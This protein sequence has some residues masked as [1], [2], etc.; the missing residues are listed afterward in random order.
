MLKKIISIFLVVC[1][2]LTFLVSCGNT[3]NTKTSGETETLKKFTA[4]YLDYFDTVSVIV[5]YDTDE[6][7]FNEKCEFI[8]EQLSEYNNLYDIYKSYEGINNIRTINQNAGL[9]PVKVDARIIG[10]LD[11]CKSVFDLTNG[12]VNVAFGSV[13]SIWHDYRTEGINNP[14]NAKLPTSDELTEA[15]KHTD[16]SKVIIDRENST[17]FLENEEM[18]LDVGAIGKGYATEQIAKA[19]IEKGV[20]NYTLNI[21]GNIRTIGSRADGS[22]WTAAITNPDTTSDIASIMTVKLNGQSF[23]TSG[24]YQRF[25]EVD[26]KRY[27]HIIDSKTLYPKNTFTSVSVLSN[28]SGLADALST[29]LFNMSLE[30]G[31]K[32]VSSIEGVEAL[33]VTDSY[34]IFYSNGFSDII[35][36]D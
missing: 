11:F 19:L 28:D 23:V 22:P 3:D 1:F 7:A 17:V 10:L 27:H 20:T 12:N 24:S 26:G 33:W 32:L 34:E 8:E 5:G 6:N 9:E 14:E 4:T 35:V 2:A 18:S 36:K 16:F 21:G 25:Y 15:A 29:A 13:L 30:E 31:K